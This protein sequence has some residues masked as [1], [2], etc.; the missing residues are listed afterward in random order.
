MIHALMLQER[1]G[2]EH[3]EDLAIGQASELIDE[4]NSATTD[5]RR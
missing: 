4:L 5:G 3:A 1:D 2:I